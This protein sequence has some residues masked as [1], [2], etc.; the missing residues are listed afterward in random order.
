MKKITGNLGIFFITLIFGFLAAL[1]LKS[2]K[3]DRNTTDSMTLRANELQVQL[4]REKETNQ[5]LYKE[6][7]EYKDQLYQFR[8]EAVKSGDYAKALA[9][10][11]E[12]AEIT[13]GLTTVKGPGVIVTMTEDS[14]LIN[15]EEIEDPNYTIIHDDDVL[16]VINELR[17]AGAEAIS[18][19]GERLLAT[20]EIRCAGAT[21]SVNNNRYSA[22]FVIKA[23][24]DPKNLEAALTMKY[25]VIDI[26]KPW[27]IN[28]DV[29][30]SEEIE[31]K[32]YTGPLQYKY[33]V[34]VPVTSE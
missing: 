3:I 32:G 22:P 6:I 27:G 17:D 24:G 23:I 14:T 18:V 8:D 28:V 21:I 31:I 2:V 10:Q 33:V 1:Q 15:E 4:N 19:N 11:L 5:K 12:R 30:T 16:K 7:L 34:P 25:G 13:A 26:L 20:S 9:K 29:K